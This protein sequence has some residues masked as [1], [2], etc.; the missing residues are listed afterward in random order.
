MNRGKE[1]NLFAAIF[2]AGKLDL[3]H[4]TST[5]GLAKNPF[6]RLRRDS[7]ARARLLGAVGGLGVGAG[8]RGAAVGRGR[9]RGTGRRSRRHVGGLLRMGIVTT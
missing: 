7:G 3:A 9:W 1:T 4:A 2:F 6:S 8:V 5:N